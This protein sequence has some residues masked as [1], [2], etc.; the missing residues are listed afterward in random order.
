MWGSAALSSGK[1]GNG[2]P[3]AIHSVVW[4][5]RDA[6]LASAEIPIYERERWKCEYTYVKLITRYIRYTRKKI[7]LRSIKTHARLQP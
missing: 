3:R 1:R 2:D 6:E 7:L 5:Y 4:E